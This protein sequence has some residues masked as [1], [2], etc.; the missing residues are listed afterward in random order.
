MTLSQ[1]CAD[2]IAADKG[3]CEDSGYQINSEAIWTRIDLAN[4][5]VL[6]ELGARTRV[7]DFQYETLCR[8]YATRFRLPTIYISNL[9][10][11]ELEQLY[12]DRATSRLG[13]GTV[14]V[15]EAPDQRT[16]THWSRT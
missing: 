12:D 4:L 1:L 15:V 8:F 14:A 9:G 2:L 13:S 7:S 11:K 3:L 16:Q 6:D 5:A 10:L